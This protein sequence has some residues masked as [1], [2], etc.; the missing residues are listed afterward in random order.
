MDTKAVFTESAYEEVM[1]FLYSRLPMFHRVG[2][3]AYKA[4]L[5]NTLLLMDHL[6]HPEKKFVC[7][8]VAGT[9]GKGSVSHMLASVLQ[10]A[11]YKTGLYT[12]PHLLDFRERIRLN[13]QMIPRDYVVS[14]TNTHR[15]ALSELQLSFFEWTVGLCFDYFASSK[16]DIAVIE[17][18]LGGRLDSTNVVTPLVSVITNIGMDH[19]DLLGETIPLIAREKAGIIKNA[20][21]VVIG[22]RSH[23]TDT[24]FLEKAA[25]ERSRITFASDSYE[26]S[27]IGNARGGYRSFRVNPL[28]SGS[29][30]VIESPLTGSCQKNNITTVLEALRI[31]A[32]KGTAVSNEHIVEGIKKVCEQTGLM[33]RWQTLEESPFTVADTGHNPPGIAQV[34]QSI[35][36]H[37]HNK[38]HLVLG[39]VQGKDVF[40]MLAMFPPQAHFYFAKPSVERGLPG[41]ELLP[42]ADELQLSYSCFSDVA[43]AW[44]A[45][46][47]SASPD[48]MIV[49]GGSTFVVADALSSLQVKQQ[50]A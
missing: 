18:G 45:A 47:A 50:T 5:S 22:E 26:L 10:E 7:I 15:T 21:P 25:R 30:F 23:E 17:T 14:F 44:E 33:G 36:A 38:L 35:E 46:R 12:S 28:R 20:V 2:K 34:V 6:G 43:S 29:P 41:T 37:P 24:V 49:I 16:V 40:S 4:D 11:G 39:F 1:S 32:E 27:R 42:F 48:D 9:N 8:H 31:L 3:A 13:G 19:T